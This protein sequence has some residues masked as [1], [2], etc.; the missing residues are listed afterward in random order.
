MTLKQ[1]TSSEVAFFEEVKK[2]WLSLKQAQQKLS[3]DKLFEERIAKKL[4]GLNAEG[5][6]E[7]PYW[8]WGL[9]DI[10]LVFS[11]RSDDMETKAIT[12]I[13]RSPGLLNKIA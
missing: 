13:A 9:H 7:D 6:E 12:I 5:A 2:I 1:N 4:S 10:S 8:M 3:Q 11:D